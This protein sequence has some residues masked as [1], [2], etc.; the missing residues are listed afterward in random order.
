MMTKTNITVALISFLFPF[1]AAAA[2]PPNVQGVQA[3]MTNGTVTVTWTAIS[4]PTSISAYRVY[5][6]H[7]SILANNGNYDDFEQTQ[8]IENGY[9]FHSIPVQSPKMYVGVLA[10]GKDGTESDGFEV[11]AS[12][13]LPPASSA[14]S[15][16]PVMSSSSSSTAPASIP[17]DQPM[18]FTAVT[19]VSS[20]GVLLSFSLPIAQKQQV[21]AGYFLIQDQSGNVLTVSRVDNQGQ[22]VLLYTA[23]QMPKKLYA[24]SLLTNLEAENGSKILL[25]TPRVQFYGFDVGTTAK[26][27]LEESS[28]SSSSEQ[29]SSSAAPEP[30]PAPD[31]TP[32]PARF[33]VTGDVTPTPTNAPPPVAPS[34]IHLTSVSDGK[35]TYKVLVEWDGGY[36]PVRGYAVY[37]TTDGYH[38][39][40]STTVGPTEH[41]ALFAGI[42]SGTYFGAKVIGILM[43]GTES[44]GISHVIRLPNTGLGLLGVAGAA[45]ALAARRKMKKQK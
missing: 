8:S 44:T 37:T 34:G 16:A 13:D 10:V 18:I 4:D 17:N 15:T 45:G 20:T 12:V 38:Y 25:S 32:P 7:E 40:L 23:V 6:S 39:D 9:T 33:P 42:K 24:I 21:V 36:A 30:A 35:D 3:T 22:N 26:P 43:D 28:S 19:P 2:T 1:A 14:S 41:S 31:Q 29:V 5:Y 27:V 11:E